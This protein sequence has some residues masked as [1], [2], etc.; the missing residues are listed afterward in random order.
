MRWED[1]VD[2][3]LVDLEQQAEGLALAERDAVVAEQRPG[4]Y[5]AVDLA[6][7][8]HASVGSLLRLEV[9]GVG[10]V[11]GRLSRVG[12]GWVLLATPGQER[13]V[14][15][16]AVVAAHGLSAGGVANAARP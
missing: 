3:M 12:D 5:A 15:L 8:L 14:R 2:R 10:L 7:R 4:E 13:V 6:G 1:Q 16:A 11:E 9:L